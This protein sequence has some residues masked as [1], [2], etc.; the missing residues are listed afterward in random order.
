V[1]TQTHKNEVALL[2]QFILFRVIMLTTVITALW[3]SYSFTGP[4][5]HTISLPVLLEAQGRILRV[6]RNKR[7][8]AGKKLAL[9]YNF[10]FTKMYINLEKY[11]II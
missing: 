10:K 4:I 7:L 2:P 1:A 6:N 3:S 5:S 8:K 11:V 9:F